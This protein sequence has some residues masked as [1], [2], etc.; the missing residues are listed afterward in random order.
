MALY[1]IL[2]TSVEREGVIFA[3]SFTTIVKLKRRLI[4]VESSRWF[5]CRGKTG[6]FCHM[7]KVPK[8]LELDLLFLPE[9]YL[10]TRCRLLKEC[11]LFFTC[12]LSRSDPIGKKSSGADGSSNFFESN[13]VSNVGSCSAFVSL[14]F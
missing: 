3:T 1:F 2:L 6:S 11:V 13:F 9:S 7:Q 10:T 12:H 8:L 5:S 4:L 14:F